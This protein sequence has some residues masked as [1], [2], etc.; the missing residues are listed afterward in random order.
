[1]NQEK[2]LVIII[3][4][5]QFIIDVMKEFIEK[6]KSFQVVASFSNGEQALNYLHSHHVDLIFLAFHLPLLNGR[7]FLIALRKSYPYHHDV[8]MV[9]YSSSLTEIRKLAALGIIDYLV[10]PLSYGRLQKALN[11]FLALNRKIS[12]HLSQEEIDHLYQDH[13]MILEKGIQKKT[14]YQIID[15]L[16]LHQKQPLTSEIISQDLHLS[17]VTIRH[18]LNYLTNIKYLILQ[19]DYG[20]GG[21]PKHIYYYQGEG[22]N[23]Q[24]I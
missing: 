12:S 17:L 7:E 14:L 22:K 15:Y 20:T 6:N 1:M 5:D 19:L 2:Y 18:Y 8:I 24:R 11:K 13:E 9:S 4:E 16:E 23:G 10:K 3:D 21:R